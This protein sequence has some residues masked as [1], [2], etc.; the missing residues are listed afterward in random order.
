MLDAPPLQTSRTSLYGRANFLPRSESLVTSQLPRQASATL[1]LN[2]SSQPSES[3]HSR[4]IVSL[5]AGPSHRQLSG[6]TASTSYLRPVQVNNLQ[7]IS[8]SS[9]QP[10]PSYI[11]EL[12]DDS[13]L[14]MRH[15]QPSNMF[16]SS[17]HR[18]SNLQLHTS[19]NLVDLT[20][21]PP[22]TRLPIRQ[23]SNRIDLDSIGSGSLRRSSSDLGS[24]QTRNIRLHQQRQQQAQ[25]SHPGH[26]AGDS[27][28]SNCLY[29]NM[30]ALQ[31]GTFGS[32]A[33][34]SSAAPNSMCSH[35]AGDFLEIS[36]LQ[37]SQ[38]W[39]NSS[40]SSLQPTHRSSVA[41]AQGHAVPTI[42]QRS[43]YACIIRASTARQLR[44]FC[45]CFRYT[46]YL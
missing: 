3:D 39:G 10:P 42:E 35:E 6:E 11:I 5:A 37:S 7:H 2:S 4:T 40:S 45:S 26:R 29:G 1:D 23:P 28:S 38:R 20:G 33:N 13:P 36:G 15:Q 17:R 21:S 41:T 25:G 24:Q 32:C 19:G 30:G 31:P 18:N 22:L 16:L 14:P 8:S 46:L 12:D 9:S 27:V 43:A 34:D 44:H